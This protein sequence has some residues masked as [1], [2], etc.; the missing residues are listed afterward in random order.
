MCIVSVLQFH[1]L[2]AQTHKSTKA[3]LL[4][5]SATDHLQCQLVLPAWVLAGRV[6][7]HLWG[8]AE[9][10]NAW[11]SHLASE[12]IEHFLSCSVSR[13]VCLLNRV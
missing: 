6:A 2:P 5:E 4:A 12:A 1:I 9:C 7:Q 8:E 10:L 3:D 11:T 13:L